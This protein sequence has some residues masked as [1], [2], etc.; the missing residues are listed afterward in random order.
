MLL[1]ERVWSPLTITKKGKIKPD[2]KITSQ[3]PNGN[4]YYPSASPEPKIT[5]KLSKIHQAAF[6][7]E[8][9]DKT[10]FITTSFME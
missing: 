8:S 9:A 2:G 7:A 10:E 1:L 5:N 6:R 4:Y 3:H